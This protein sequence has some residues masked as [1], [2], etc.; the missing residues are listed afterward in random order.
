MD[1]GILSWASNLACSTKAL[2]TA[3]A[4]VRKNSEMTLKLKRKQNTAMDLSLLSVRTE[5]SGKDR[6]I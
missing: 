2:T 6:N 4:N 5:A 3:M 1:V